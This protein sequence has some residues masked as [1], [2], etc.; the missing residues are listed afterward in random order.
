MS[1]PGRRLCLA[2]WRQPKGL[3][4]TVPWAGDSELQT[5]EWNTTAEGT[6]EEAWDSRRSKAPFLGRTRGISLCT[7]RFSEGVAPLVQAM[8][9]KKPPAW[10]RGDQGFLVWTMGF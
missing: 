10:V 9:G 2:V 3:R 4:S 8:G 1:I 6:T 7:H 5:G